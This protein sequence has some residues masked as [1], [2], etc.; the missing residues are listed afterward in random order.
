MQDEPEG[1]SALL[2]RSNRLDDG[3]TFFHPHT[4]TLVELKLHR[5]PMPE[6]KL[7]G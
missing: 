3:S 2:I 7:F 5:D 4:T 1:R 6:Y